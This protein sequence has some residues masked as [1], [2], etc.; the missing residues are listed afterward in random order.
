V[1]KTS[2]SSLKCN[3]TAKHNLETRYINAHNYHAL[4]VVDLKVSSK[5]VLVS[6]LIVRTKKLQSQCKSET[7]SPEFLILVLSSMVFIFRLWHFLYYQNF[8]KYLQHS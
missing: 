3:C 4:L 5:D 1:V 2:K 6:E 8:M 7:H